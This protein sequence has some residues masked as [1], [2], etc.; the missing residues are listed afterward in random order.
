VLREGFTIRESLLF[1]CGA[2]LRT[3]DHTR[4]AATLELPMLTASPLFDE[5]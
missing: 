2:H 1:D 3:R 4:S 5:S